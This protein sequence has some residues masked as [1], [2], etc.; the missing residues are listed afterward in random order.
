L[1]GNFK[2]QGIIVV[3]KPHSGPPS[4]LIRDRVENITYRR[5]RDNLIIGTEEPAYE[6]IQVTE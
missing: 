1:A 4:V 5:D 6:E 2:G 3:E